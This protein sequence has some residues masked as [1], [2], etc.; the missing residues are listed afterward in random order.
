MVI[1]KKYLY[2]LTS[3]P[4]PSEIKTTTMCYSRFHSI[5]VSNVIENNSVKKLLK[6]IHPF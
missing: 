4:H 2:K 3:G 1:D 6:T 5:R